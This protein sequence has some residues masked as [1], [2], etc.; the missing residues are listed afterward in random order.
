M[1]CSDT[2]HYTNQTRRF[3]MVV[4]G[5]KTVLAIVILMVIVVIGILLFFVLRAPG[6]VGGDTYASIKEISLETDRIQAEFLDDDGFIKYEDAETVSKKVYD[7]AE[8]LVYQGK[9]KSA[10]IHP[11]S[12]IVAFFIPEEFDHLYIPPIKNTNANGDEYTVMSVTS[13][14]NISNLVITAISKTN[15]YFAGKNIYDN[16]DEYTTF[17]NITR[18]SCTIKEIKATMQDLSDI[19]TRVIFWR[20]HGGVYDKDGVDHVVFTVNEKVNYKTKKEY[21]SQEYKDCL[22]TS[23]D[24]YLITS[25]FFKQ[26]MD[27]VQCGLFFS[28]ICS[29]GADN[30]IMAQTLFDKGFDCYFGTVEIY[31]QLTLMI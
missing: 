8:E 7:Y 26:F 13:L 1:Y 31:G 10:T 24:H 5:K 12:H 18:D 9:I 22:A 23:G 11:I 20:G 4:G 25:F 6:S 29:G 17:N 14:D 15:A 19:N 2:I 27:K 28:G 21:E 3:E 30:G 16:A